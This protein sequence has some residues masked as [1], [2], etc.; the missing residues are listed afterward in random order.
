MGDIRRA[1][2][3]IQ[4]IDP[5][6]TITINH[7]VDAFATARAEER[8]QCAKECE[9]LHADSDRWDC[10]KALRKMGEAITEA[11]KPPKPKRR[12]HTKGVNR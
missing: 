1:I 5:D 2:D 3:V 11:R 4:G 7:L 8:E 9:A 12:S 6:G 10:A